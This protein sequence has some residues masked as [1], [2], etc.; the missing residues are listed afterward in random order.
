MMTTN[1]IKHNFSITRISDKIFVLFLVMFAIIVVLLTYGYELS[2]FSLSIDEEIHSFSSETWRVWISQGRW[3]MGILTYIFPNGMS[4][5]PFIPTFLFA[6]GLAL[7]A[8]I[9]STVLTNSREGAVVFTGIFISS[10]IW[11][12]IAEFSTLSWGF[13]LGLIVTAIAFWNINEGGNKK[14]LTAGVCIGFSLAVYQALIFLYLTAVLLICI[15]KEWALAAD[16][17]SSFFSRNLLIF[18][19]VF[20]SVLVA[21]V[22]YLL[23][24]YIFMYLSGSS[25]TYLDNFIKLSEYT[26]GQPGVV[27]ERVLIKTKGL[28]FGTDPTFL[29]AGVA[30]LLLFWIGMLFVTKNLF[31][32]RVTI[33]TKTYVVTLS[34]VAVLLAMSLIILSAGYIPTRALIT[35]PVL[36]ATLSAFALNY[37]KGKILLRL[38]F[39]AAL[40]T[41]IFIANSLFYAD[42][43]ARQRDLIMATRLIDRIEDVGRGV[44]GEKIPLIIV[45]SWQHEVGDPALRVEIFGDSFFE[46]DGGNPY[47]IAAYLRLLGCR[48]LVPLPITEVY[49]GLVDIQLH[50]SWPAKEAVFRTK[51]AV[52]VKLSEPS[53]QQELALHK[54]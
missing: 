18:T 35:F 27:F 44:F 49:E 54:N 22:V 34:I 1:N 31:D 47:R 53:Y 21:V 25:V 48:G 37:K 45:G 12:H 30:S 43:V 20:K 13:S 42:H 36:Y 11:L 6:M 7:S 9:F 52:I 3:G 40:F 5:I 16:R 50:P 8:V 23:F 41:N 17:N 51:S 15:K 10:P 39:C 28:L 33:I 2:N 26:N 46:H 19:D 29:G 4:T 14:A 24:N 32:S 38:I